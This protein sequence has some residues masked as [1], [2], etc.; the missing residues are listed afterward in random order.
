MKSPVYEEIM[1]CGSYDDFARTLS[2]SGCR[3]CGLAPTRSNIVVHRGNPEARIMIIGEAP[4]A[5]EDLQ[6]KAFVGRAGKMLDQVFQ[7]ID[8]DTNRDS[9][10]ANVVKCR[11]PGNRVP[12]QSEA[13]TCIAYL[14]KQIELIQ[15][16]III[17]LG[18]TAVKHLLPE[19]SK[20]PMK[21]IVGRML[22][23]SGYPEIRFIVLYHP[24]YLLYDPRKKKDMLEHLNGLKALLKGK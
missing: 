16:E 24:A 12:R 18:S 1:N 9:L 4:G 8:F 10:I 14:N 3:E 22:T 15:P 2:G 17:L 20:T 19:H 23:H 11:P 6:G 21:E 5:E 13:R 7:S